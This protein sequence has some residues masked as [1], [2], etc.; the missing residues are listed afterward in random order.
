MQQG[1]TAF[2][3]ADG[4][5]TMVKILK[6]EIDLLLERTL[7]PPTYALAEGVYKNTATLTTDTITSYYTIPIKST[8][9]SIQRL[10]QATGGAEGMRNLV[11]SDLPKLLKQVFDNAPRFGPRVF[12]LG[13]FWSQHS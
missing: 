2:G 3:N 5:N 13:E 8:L 10:M 9:R 6:A 12:A 1:L 11:D 4:I 7:P